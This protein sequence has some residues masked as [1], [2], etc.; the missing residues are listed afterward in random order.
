MPYFAAFLSQGPL[1]AKLPSLHIVMEHATTEEAV[2]FKLAK[3]L[4]PTPFYA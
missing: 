3:T 1:K 4:H 2:R